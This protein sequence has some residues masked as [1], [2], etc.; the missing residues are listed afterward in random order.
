MFVR[1]GLTLGVIG[2][3]IGLAAALAMMR[4]MSSV[5]FEISPWIR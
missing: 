1:H 4:L 5:L 2:A 3:A